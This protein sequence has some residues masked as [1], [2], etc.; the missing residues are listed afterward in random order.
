V[1]ALVVLLLIVR[2]GA[3]GELLSPQNKTDPTG[4]AGNLR[5]SIVAQDEQYQSGKRSVAADGILTS[6][7]HSLVSAKNQLMHHED[8]SQ[9]FAGFDA[10]HYPGDHVMQW[11]LHNT[12]LRWTGFYLAPAP[13]E[14]STKWMTKYHYLKDLGWG[15]API[16]VG[17]Q[18]V[19]IRGSHILTTEQGILDARQAVNLANKTGFPRGSVIFLDIETGGN[20]SSGFAEYYQAWVKEIF[21]NNYAAGTYSSFS[22]TVDQLHSIDNRVIFWVF[23]LNKYNCSANGHF[24]YPQPNPSNSG[25]AYASSWQLIQDCNI[26]SYG[27]RNIRVDLDSA[28]T[29]DPSQ[30]KVNLHRS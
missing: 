28:S 14:V 6:S 4:S 3:S 2:V 27:A 16:F 18:E 12:N 20:L 9:G 13:G 19:R 5:A 21:N 25:I 30:L 8:P 23:N 24:P 15:F 7:T 26:S 17:Q 11:L 22:K 1:L 29:A 10:V